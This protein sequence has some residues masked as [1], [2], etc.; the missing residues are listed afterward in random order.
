M[1]IRKRKTPFYSIGEER[2]EKEVF[3]PFIEKGAGRK[4]T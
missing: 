2:K 3:I 1:V 4:G